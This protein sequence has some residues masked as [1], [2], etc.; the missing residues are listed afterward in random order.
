[1]AGM[2]QTVSHISRDDLGIAPESTAQDPGD[3]RCK[4]YRPRT[5]A[6]D[7]ENFQGSET[8]CPGWSYDTDDTDVSRCG[9]AEQHFRRSAS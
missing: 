8:P 5:L 7:A 9:V 1:M 2:A 3:M 4:S 6:L